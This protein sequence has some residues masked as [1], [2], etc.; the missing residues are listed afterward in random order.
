MCAFNRAHIM[1]YSTVRKIAC[2]Q[3]DV[4]FSKSDRFEASIVQEVKSTRW[5]DGWVLYL[6][7]DEVIGQSRK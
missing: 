4:K 6:L 3:S 2:T 5:V 7:D 1:Q